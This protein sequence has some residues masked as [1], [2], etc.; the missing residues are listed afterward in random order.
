MRI[1]VMIKPSIAIN[2]IS[3]RR[4]LLFDEA[5]GLGVRT[6]LVSSIIESPRKI[7]FSVQF[8]VADRNRLTEN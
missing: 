3:R 8:S 6:S 2:N 4:S 5:V 7:V 1:A